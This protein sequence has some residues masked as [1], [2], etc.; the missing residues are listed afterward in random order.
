MFIR[1][2]CLSQTD[3]CAK[4]LALLP[5]ETPHQGVRRPGESRPNAMRLVYRHYADAVATAPEVFG[6]CRGQTL[7][8]SE[9]D[10]APDALLGVHRAP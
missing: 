7:H 9:P 3:P 8:R 5:G 2:I 6:A 4:K 10:V 1:L